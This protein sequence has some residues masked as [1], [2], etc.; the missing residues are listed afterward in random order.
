MERLKLWLKE[1]KEELLIGWGA[2]ATLIAVGLSIF[3]I[4]SI[5]IT[6]DLMEMV[7]SKEEELLVAKERVGAAELRELYYRSLYEEVELLYDNMITEYED[8][9]PKREYIQE[10]EYLESVILELRY[11]CEK[12]IKDKCNCQ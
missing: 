10:V 1:N 8:V 5:A 9:V 7:E 4:V 12:E 11:Q 6:N 3:T 2:L